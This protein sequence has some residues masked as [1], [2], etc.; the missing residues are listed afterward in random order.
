[1]NC[2]QCG[3]ENPNDAFFCSRCGASIHGED[4]G[5]AEQDSDAFEALVRTRLASEYRILR[6]LGK[7][8][9]AVVFEAH[10]LELDRRV[11]LKALPL[12]HAHDQHLVS[13]FK[14]EARLAAGLNHPHIVQIYNVG[15]QGPIH[16]FTMPYLSQGSLA[17]MIQTGMEINLA[18]TIISQIGSALDYA[19]GKGLIHRDIK[20]GNIMFDEHNIPQILDFGIA[21]ALSGTQLATL[22]MTATKGFVGTP[23]YMS[24]EQALGEEVDG[25]TDIYAL[26]VVFFQMLTGTLP[27]RGK[28]AIA[29]MYQHVNKMPP[30]P[31]KY[32]R[33]I[34]FGLD[35]IVLK[36]IA[37]KPEERFQTAGEFVLA[38]EELGLLNDR[39]T[40]I[41]PNSSLSGS[42]NVAGL[43]APPAPAEETTAPTEQAPPP[44][45]AAQPTA[46]PT[47]TPPNVPPA[48]LDPGP[49][50]EDKPKMAVG[51]DAMRRKQ[52]NIWI[53]AGLGL[54]LLVVLGLFMIPRGHK[55]EE[56]PPPETVNQASR[57]EILDDRAQQQA[58]SPADE[59]G[60]ISQPAPMPFARINDDPAYSN[61]QYLDQL[62]S[63]RSAPA[64]PPFQT[65]LADGETSPSETETETETKA[66]PET[67]TAGPPPEESN[68]AP[69]PEPVPEPVSKPK[70][71]TTTAETPRSKPKETQEARE[72]RERR[73]I[74]GLLER[75]T[76]VAV[77]AGSFRMGTRAR[78]YPDERP[79]RKIEMSAFQITKTEV[80]Q[81]LWSAVMGFNNSC[82]KAETLPVHGVSWGEI[83]SFLSRL[84]MF[85]GR[86]FR[87]PTEAEWEYACAGDNAKPSS[88]WFAANTSGI[89]AVGQK[90]ANKFGLHDM[91]G[92]VWEWVQ[93][94]YEVGYD[95][96]A[97]RTNPTG[98]SSGSQR[99]IRGGAYNTDAGECRCQNR[100]SRPPIHRDCGIGFR[101]VAVDE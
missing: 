34:P 10:M 19:H 7:G 39:P 84:Q 63:V 31:N 91:Q 96:R 58:D 68:P 27:F 18:V 48:K 29:V 38:L 25:R 45:P 76:F 59:A 83:E 54:F 2:Q 15:S 43:K 82:T 32:R 77:P 72:A 33:D 60:I 75:V 66:E 85:T 57:D 99:V 61:R 30:D 92:N 28:D 26:G 46:S 14:R 56:T 49:R 86:K 21:K 100:D 16:Y 11:A 12:A 53:A 69:K 79:Q 20:P 67:S 90:A 89:E 97:P 3:Q 95:K 64:V 51:S 24:P 47:V 78:R 44:V 40:T 88:A 98:P 37:K 8:G 87:L 36:M 74:Q 23:H 65:A 94:W 13:R 6:E 17:D 81:E 70:P 71:S 41:P 73:K 93:D 9:M 1:M 4:V 22:N 42:F 35:D 52:Q 62:W 5:M 50:G 101:L 80:T 55:T